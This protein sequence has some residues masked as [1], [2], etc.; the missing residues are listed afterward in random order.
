MAK[1][2]T[3]TP[4]LPPAAQAL[5]AIDSKLREFEAEDL[6]LGADMR[7]RD[8]LGEKL[9]DTDPRNDAQVEALEMITGTG[10]V[11]TKRTTYVDAFRRREAVKAAITM[12][13]H[14]REQA[15][16]RAAWERFEAVADEHAECWSRI[17]TMLIGIE[18][19]LQAK[20][21]IERQV[22]GGILFPG[23]QF[24]LLGRLARSHSVAY[25]MLEAGVENGWLTAEDFADEVKQASDAERR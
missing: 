6:A 14:H 21:E 1:A 5:A 18:R 13:E 7:R 3:P 20:D 10:K 11:A 19:E 25:R 12:L 24:K 8:A 2:Q 9:N 22:G 4:T 16:M 17:C 15:A 23:N